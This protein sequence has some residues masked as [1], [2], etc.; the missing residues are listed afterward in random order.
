MYSNPVPKIIAAVVA[1]AVVVLAL[2]CTVAVPARSVGVA[3]TFGKIDPKPMD[4]GLHFKGPF[5]KVEKMDGT[6]Q[7]INNEWVFADGEKPKDHRTVVRLNNNSIMFVENNLRWR[8]KLEAAP[9]L[10]QDWKAF[11]KI[12]SGLVDKELKIALN[13]ALSDYDPLNTTVKRPSNEELSAKVKAILDKRVGVNSKDQKIEVVSFGIVKIDFDDRTQ[14]QIEQ[15]KRATAAT[16]EAQQNV[17]TA[18]ANAQANN[19]LAKSVQNPNV[20]TSKC[21]DIVAKGTPLPAGFSCFSGQSGTQV[22][23]ESNPK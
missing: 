14:E 5:T 6:N 15:V 22:V 10:F 11:D 7:Q 4:S 12:E 8:I 1:V 9:A 23:T 21:L 19:E 20:L 17:Q 13:D 16:R 18:K 2:A 3:S